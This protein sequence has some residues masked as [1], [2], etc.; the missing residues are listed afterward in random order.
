MKIN[1]RKLNFYST[2]H[3]TSARDCRSNAFI[4]FI[5]QS[6]EKYKSNFQCSALFS[7]QRHY[8][9]MK[10][11]LAKLK[12]PPDLEEEEAEQEDEKTVIHT[13]LAAT[14]QASSS[15]QA[16]VQPKPEKQ[17]QGEGASASAL[18]SIDGVMEQ[19]LMPDGLFS[20]QEELF[21]TDSPEE[22]S[23]YMYLDGGSLFNSPMPPPDSPFTPLPGFP[24][25]MS[26][27][28]DI[29]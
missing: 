10:E 15:V 24:D 7:A 4:L 6:Y 5:H 3:I 8:N 27:D 9:Q 25:D 12:P 17:E 19:S 20:K 16:E 11:E 18:P 29:L 22:D 23:P 21:E 28:T 13:N 2:T 14:H 1:Y 26:F